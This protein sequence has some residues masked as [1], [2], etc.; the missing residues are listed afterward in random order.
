MTDVIAAYESGDQKPIV[1]FP[2]MDSW[3]YK[4]P[5]EWGGDEIID[6]IYSCFPRIKVP[7][8]PECRGENFSSL[9]GPQLMRMTSADFEKLDPTYGRVFYEMFQL[10]IK[11]SKQQ[12]H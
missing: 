8:E 6:W 5:E 9:S 3:T 10:L 4:H 2:A 11:N 1:V 12:L 7:E